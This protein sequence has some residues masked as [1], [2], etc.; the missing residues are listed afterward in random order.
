MKL[1]TLKSI[2]TEIY[3]LPYNQTLEYDKYT[4]ISPNYRLLLLT[5]RIKKPKFVSI[6]YVLCTSAE[7]H[8]VAS[9]I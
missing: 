1:H 4:D 7:F 5:Q 8:N 9:I 3:R 2:Q 6:V